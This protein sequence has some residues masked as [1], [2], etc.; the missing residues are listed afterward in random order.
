VCWTAPRQQPQQHAA[1]PLLL[2]AP[3]RHTTTTKHQDL[4]ALVARGTARALRRKLAEAVDDFSAAIK[5]EP[6]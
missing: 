4:G 5:L 2:N 6:R 3:S 1:N